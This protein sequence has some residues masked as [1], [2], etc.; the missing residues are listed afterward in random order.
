VR[1]RCAA[2]GAARSSAPICTCT[3]VAQPALPNRLLLQALHIICTTPACPSKF[4]TPSR[5]WR[6]TVCHIRMSTDDQIARGWLRRVPIIKKAQQQSL[7]GAAEDIS[8]V[9]TSFMLALE[10]E[11]SRDGYTRTCLLLRYDQLYKLQHCLH[12]HQNIQVLSSF[13]LSISIT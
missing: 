10:C 3:R 1:G 7:P 13:S 11:V 5:R 9:Y 12:Q 8:A 2:G 6:L 4:T